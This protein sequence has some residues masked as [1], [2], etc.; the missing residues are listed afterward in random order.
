MSCVAAAG[1]FRTAAAGVTAGL[2]RA[3]LV[4]SGSTPN[5]AICA[6]SFLKASRN[7]KVLESAASE[8]QACLS[9]M[10]LLNLLKRVSICFSYD[11]RWVISTGGEDRAVF[12]WEVV[13]EEL[14]RG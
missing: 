9:A 13:R 14:R 6:R 10:A 12:Q 4:S 11:D 2:P 1:L 5:L 7:F 3:A 8:A